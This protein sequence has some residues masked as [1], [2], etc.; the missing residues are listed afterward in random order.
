[1]DAPSPS[2]AAS[3]R[4]F[5]PT[6]TSSPNDEQ[7]ILSPRIRI[8]CARR[9]FLFSI[10]C[11]ANMLDSYSLNAIFAGLPA[12]KAAFAMGEVEASWVMSAFQLTY[13]AFLLIVSPSLCLRK[14][15]LLTAHLQSGRISD[16]YHPSTLRRSSR[17]GYPTDFVYD[18]RACIHPRGVRARHV[19]I[20]SR[21]SEG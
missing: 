3:Q 10:F 9:Y 2:K 13:A 7:A 1:M 17:H 5:S 19:F 20:G 16:V 8:S 11:I 14:G 4:T 15:S 12:L 21:L 6:P 18:S